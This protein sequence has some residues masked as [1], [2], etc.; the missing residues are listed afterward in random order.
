MLLILMLIFRSIILV[1]LVS[2]FLSC[3]VFVILYVF[4]CTYGIITCYTVYSR[5]LCTTVYDRYT[6]TPLAEQVLQN[7]EYRK[8]VL[9]RTPMGRVGT[10]AETAGIVA[11]LCMDASSYITGQVVAVDG[12]F[13]RNG[14]F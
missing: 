9:D 14:F 1:C 2:E 3:S 4:V 13:L 10:P 11:F 5:P 8:S 6:S 12:G 7:P